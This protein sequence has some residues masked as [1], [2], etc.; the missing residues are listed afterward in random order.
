MTQA[1][2]PSP[3]TA[4]SD[5][6]DALRARATGKAL[7]HR[8]YWRKTLQI[9]FALL[10]VWLLV[11]LLIGLWVADW[12]AQLFGWPVGYWAASQGALGVYCLIVWAYAWLMDRLGERL[13]DGADDSADADRRNGG[14]DDAN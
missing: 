11:T 7:R 6:A 3:L 4:N 5:S 13:G 14:R 9:T 12:T 8:L 1:H 2:I 10:S